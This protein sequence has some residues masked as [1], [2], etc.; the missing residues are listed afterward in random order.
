VM[1]NIASMSEL[2]TTIQNIILQDKNNAMCQ[3]LET[4]LKN[5]ACLLW[6]PYIN[7]AVADSKDKE[8]E[9]GGKGQKSE[10]LVEGYL[11]PLSKLVKSDPS[12][13]FLFRDSPVRSLDSYYSESVVSMFSRKRYCFACQANE[14]MF[15]LH[16]QQGRRSSDSDSHLAPVP[17]PLAGQPCGC[18][19]SLFCTEVVA[20]HSRPVRKSPSAM[21]AVQLLKYH[22]ARVVA[23]QQ[24]Q[25]ALA[26]QTI[27]AS[28][29]DTGLHLSRRKHD[30]KKDE[31]A[32]TLQAARNEVNVLLAMLSMNIWKC[33]HIPNSLHP[34]SAGQLEHVK[35]VFAQ[36]ALLPVVG[37]E[38]LVPLPGRATGGSVVGTRGSYISRSKENQSQTDAA[39]TV[40]AV[41]DRAAFELFASELEPLVDE[42]DWLD[43]VA[44]SA[45]GSSQST[46]EK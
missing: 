11:Y 42:V 1:S 21:D 27:D 37:F 17:P 40:I 24:Q 7:S 22:C 29:S 44:G 18:T 39:K 41:D 35:E 8:D 38:R 19:Q 45:S 32:E 10:S 25:Q 5:D 30:R 2:Y 15:G 4:L 12:E 3:L 34:Y 13:K 31:L 23:L 14:G 26:Q 6:I 46:A 43:A 16:G 28:S 36:C 20:K 33:F 9:Q